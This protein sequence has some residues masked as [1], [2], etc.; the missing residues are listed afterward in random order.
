MGASEKRETAITRT[1]RMW[2]LVT[3]SMPATLLTWVESKERE[4]G[5]KTTRFCDTDERAQQSAGALP[6]VEYN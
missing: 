2:L 4:K 6:I 1:G 3:A 5:I